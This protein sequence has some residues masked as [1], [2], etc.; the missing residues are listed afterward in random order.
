MFIS[1]PVF[2]TVALEST[3]ISETPLFTKFLG[4]SR[5]LVF[6]QINCRI[7]ESFPYEHS[8]GVLKIF[9]WQNKMHTHTDTQRAR[10]KNPH[11]TKGKLKELL[12]GCSQSG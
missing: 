5:C 9:L 4:Y 2:M 1:V 3:L 10:S 7:L 8:L 11:K 6:F 12:K